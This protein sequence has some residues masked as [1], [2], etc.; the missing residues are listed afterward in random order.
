MLFFLS[1][2]PL[3]SLTL[4]FPFFSF[5][6]SLCFSFSFSGQ[7]RSG[8]VGL[9][10]VRLGWVG[11]GWVRPGPEPVRRMGV[12]GYG[13]F[14]GMIFRS[15]GEGGGMTGGHEHLVSLPTCASPRPGSHDIAQHKYN[16]GEQLSLVV[17]VCNCSTV[18]VAPHSGISR[19]RA[20]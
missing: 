9:D 3:L 2:F 17:C 6:L 15:L 18:A 19:Q 5:P 13:L 12:G 14:R 20:N 1:P 16:L 8:P 4:P 10:R 7:V 11:L